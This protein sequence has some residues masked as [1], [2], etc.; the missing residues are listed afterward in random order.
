MSFLQL[1]VLHI[2]LGGTTAT[3]L[4]GIKRVNVRMG[5]EAKSN[6][7]DII[8]KNVVGGALDSAGNFRFK[9]KDT[10]KI[11]A[12][13]IDDG[14]DID[15]SSTTH[16]LTIANIIEFSG[17]FGQ[18]PMEWTIKCADRT[19]LLLNRL[20]ANAYKETDTNNTAP[21]IVR[22]VVRQT[23][24]V[25]NHLTDEGFIEADGVKYA[26]SAEFTSL[27]GGIQNTRQNASA[28][29]NINI[30]RTF[31]PIYEWLRDLSSIENTNSETELDPADSTA[32][33]QKRAMRF[34]VDENNKFFWFYP[35]DTPDLFL[36]EG[37]SKGE[38]YRSTANTVGAKVSSVELSKEQFDSVNMIIF[39]AGKDIN[40]AGILDYVF[41]DTQPIKQLKMTY[42]A[43]PTIVKTLLKQ[44]YEVRPAS[45]RKNTGGTPN[46]PEF[47]LDSL[48]PFVPAWGGT[49]VGSDAAYNS[50]LRSKAR[51]YGKNKVRELITNIGGIRW[52]GRMTT[53]GAKFNP[54]DLIFY[55]SSSFSLTD[56]D[57]RITDVIHNFSDDSWTTSLTVE[58]DENEINKGGA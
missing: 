10:I 31:K 43:F 53:E 21:E 51:D 2:P 36:E 22:D 44:D 39:S 15:T 7:S 27:G 40:G 45:S 50:S 26:I 18:N 23:S 38:L 35:D 12:K 28:F 52:R 49:S 57:L 42:R 37:K 29:P 48:Y 14:I 4:T 30:A 1:K 46:E 41:D 8:I 9:E 3:E 47:P 34:L 54:G 32:L 55:T 11:Y 13:V 17:R 56:Q 16:L 25:T 6:T 58:E 19:Y 20:F 33:V 5:S 24:K